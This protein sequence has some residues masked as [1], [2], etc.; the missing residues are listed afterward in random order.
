MF[1]L[2]GEAE[3]DITYSVGWGLAQSEDFA[4]I[5]LGEAYGACTAEGELTA[6]RLQETDK[7]TGRTD[8]EIESKRLHLI[9]EAKR[10]WELPTYGQLK[11]YAERLRSNE[12]REGCVLVV[13]ECAPYYP[14]VAALPGEIFGIPI[15]YMAWSRVAELV[16]RSASACRRPAERRLLLDLHRYL[17]RLTTVQNTTSNLV[18][19]VTLQDK[20]LDWS[21]L[22][23]KQIVYDR[24][25]YFHSIGG[26]GGWPKTPVKLSR[27]PVRCPP[28]AHS[29]CR[30][31][32]GH[33]RASH[34]LAGNPCGSIVGAD[35]HVHART[36]HRAD[37]EDPHGDM[38]R[39]AR[40]WAALDLL[41]TSE[42]ITQARDLTRAR[43]EAAGIPFP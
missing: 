3:D 34:I 37:E 42:T 1:D 21:D 14:P 29:A 22:T 26:P 11:Q 24:D 41:L 18:Y 16:E 28:A 35:L 38:H 23:F 19:V 4:R 25:R 27:L 15:M 20:P 6:V 32:R 40:A 36:G 39:N 7:L 31:L 5:L 43:H 33:Y 17:R 13:S 2:L 30:R 9:V 10:G 8:V 12:Q